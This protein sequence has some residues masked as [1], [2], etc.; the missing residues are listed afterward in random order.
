MFE[1]PNR[2][3]R[4]QSSRADLKSSKEP[5]SCHFCSG[6]AAADMVVVAVGVGDEERCRVKNGQRNRS[7]TCERLP[8]MKVGQTKYL[9]ILRGAK[10]GQTGN[11]FRN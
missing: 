5:N 8:G 11:I 4:T 2:R 10:A 1:Q 3:E 7:L 9:S 6:Q